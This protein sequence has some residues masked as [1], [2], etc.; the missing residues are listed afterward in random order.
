MTQPQTLDVEYAELMARANEIEQPLPRIPSTNPSAPCALAIA[1]DAVTQLVLSADSIRLYLKGCEREWKTLAKSLRKAA[2]AYEEVDEGAADGINNEG[3]A[4]GGNGQMSAFDDSDMPW[5][6]PAPR[7]SPTP[8]EDPYYEVRQATTDMEA[9]DQGT[10]CEAF[11]Q[12]WRVFQL[13]LQRETFRFRPFTSWEGDARTAV[14]HD[15]DLQRQW[16]ADMV[17]L[18]SKL[19]EQAETIIAAQKKLRPATGNAEY[20]PQYANAAEHPGPL[21]IAWCDENYERG[22]KRRDQELISF[23]IYWYGILQEKS[24]AALKIYR[25]GTSLPP[26][27]PPMFPTTSVADIDFGSGIS[28]DTNSGNSGDVNFGSPAGEL[29]SGDGLSGLP[30]MPTLPTTGMPATPNTS[31][32]GGAAAKMPAPAAGKGLP[33]GAMVKPASLGGGGAAV[34]GLPLQSWAG[35]GATSGAGAAGVGPGRAIPVPA[36]YAALNGGGGGMGMPMGAPGGQG[37]NAGKGKR[38]EQEGAALYTEDR[39][40]TQGIIGQR[41]A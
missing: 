29:A 1:N 16:I 9:G 3:Y 28:D 19:S 15:F 36:A 33:A 35:A 14:E 31:M 30:G 25:E 40:W 4:P 12:E 20:E 34:P 41:R 6:P 37:Q 24:E 21:D 5:D 11:A 32:P 13:T 22:V 2:K 7:P 38:V 23:A 8:V 10:A 18:C 27:N 26:L 17:D 39:A